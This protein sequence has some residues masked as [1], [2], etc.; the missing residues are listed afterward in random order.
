WSCNPLYHMNLRFGR[1]CHLN[2]GPASTSA[3][4]F[5]K[6]I[7]PNNLRPSRRSCWGRRAWPGGGGQ[8]PVFPAKNLPFGP[9][10]VETYTI[11]R[12]QPWST[13]VRWTSVPF[14]LRVAGPIPVRGACLHYLY[15]D[16]LLCIYLGSTDLRSSSSGGGYQSGIGVVPMG[17]LACFCC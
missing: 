14:W 2:P 12:R 1:T 8:G 15:R 13:F 6:S 16:R 10:D 5:L 7:S 3:L 4:H 9:R 17:T 11:P